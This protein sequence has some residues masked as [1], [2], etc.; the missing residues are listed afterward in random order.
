MT[1]KAAMDT[2]LLSRVVHELVIYTTEYLPV[3]RESGMR[4]DEVTH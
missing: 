3:A 1:E 2:N 4:D